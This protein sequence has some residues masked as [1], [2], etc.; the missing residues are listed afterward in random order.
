[1]TATGNRIAKGIAGPGDLVTYLP[2]DFSF[3]VRGVLNKVN[4]CLFIIAETEI[5]PNLIRCL[6]RKNIPVILVNGRV[7]DASFR[8]YCAIR[9]LLKP[10]L[11]RI[12]LFCVQSGRDQ[13]RLEYLGAAPDRIRVTGNMKFDIQE[14]LVL[15]TDHLLHLGLRPEE[16][17]LAAGS[18]HPGE[19]EIIL[20]AYKDLLTE[21]SY[22]RLLIAPRHPERARDIEKLVLK[23]GF[24]PV[25]ISTFGRTA[26]DPSTALGAGARRTTVFIL[27]TIGALI[28]YYALA[29]IIFVG[30]SLVKK[31]GHN[32][33]EPASLGKPIIF[34]PH[35]FN[36]RDIA[37]LFLM[38]Q[39]AL[40]IDGRDGLKGALRGIL[41]ST[42]KAEALAIKS[43][44]LVSVN[45]G[46]TGK[47]MGLI[48]S[49][50]RSFAGG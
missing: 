12:S 27:D 3:T 24:H 50:L 47:N 33:L 49:Y 35:M 6:F 16:R 9:F 26:H 22:L 42:P 43:R 41:V 13:Q 21:F 39:A 14:P 19:E 45:R 18:T 34:G 32:I 29:D 38:H 10:V 20:N 30:G 11:R 40:Q 17:L 15:K 46:A 7:S 4:P 48:S 1:V 36:F 44:Q 25:F 2:L 28:H 23:Y 37:D 5:W 31:G 8:G